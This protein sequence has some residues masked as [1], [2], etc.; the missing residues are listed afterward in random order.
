[1]A[2]LLMKSQASPDTPR[3]PRKDREALLT[4]SNALPYMAPSYPFPSGIAPDQWSQ[5]R[6]KKHP[7]YT[8]TAKYSAT[9]PAKPYPEVPHLHVF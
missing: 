3:T 7:T 5:T 1:M 9:I 6:G 8:F 4:I 2:A